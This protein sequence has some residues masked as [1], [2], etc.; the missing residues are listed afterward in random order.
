[1]TMRSLVRGG[2]VIFLSFACLALAQSRPASRPGET[3]EN[4]VR[5]I[6]IG[7]DAPN[8]DLPGV[9]G[10]Q[11]RL[12]DFA[13]AKILMVVFTCNHCPTAQ[14]Y[15]GRLQKIYD[16]YT[17]KGVAVVAISPSDPKGLR[18]D[19][20]G[21]TDLSD[22]FDEMKIR[23]QERGFKFPYLYDGDRQDVSTAYG[24]P[25]TPTVFI[26]DEQRKL[27]YVGR[28]DDADREDKVKSHDARNALDALLA[29]KEVPVARTKSFGCS[30]KWSDKR[31][32]VEAAMKKLAAQAV[33]LD[34]LDLNGVKELIQNKSES[35]RL[36]NAW[37]LS[38]VPC[39]AEIPELVTINRMYAQRSFEFVTLNTDWSDER[40]KAL[41][42]LKKQ[43]A[44]NRNVMYSGGNKND[45]IDLIDKNWDGGLPY[46]MLIKPGGE[47]VF[48]QI[49]PIDP[50]RLKRA[51]VKELGN[52]H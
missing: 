1:M 3:K 25:A 31:A 32:S 45:I 35:Y 51:I 48:R 4:W 37:M 18:L 14:A 8:F 29:G 23:A 39:L 30:T 44:A 22:T 12:A 9:D 33:T 13:K 49:G 16:D 21:Y 19:E 46:T 24:V 7:S 6:A 34:S 40:D 27:R 15:E 52:R 10:K 11:H 43:Q 28:I 41:A 50:L 38:C 20:L 17:P 36:V 42:F 2:V 26:F 5:P 47:V